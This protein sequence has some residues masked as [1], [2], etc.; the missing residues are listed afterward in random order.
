MPLTAAQARRIA[1]SFAGATER[2][3]QGGL[4]IRIG[5][6]YFVRIGTREPDTVQFK[7]ESFE[8]RD[9]MIAAE[10]RLFYITD[11]WRSYKGLLARLSALD[12]KT[13]RALLKQ[14]LATLEA[15]PKKKKRT[16]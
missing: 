7:L 16:R 4:E 13:L 12:A 8:E 1:L 14:R 5:D 3:S 9:A 10:P 6:D 11:H 15:G 2:W